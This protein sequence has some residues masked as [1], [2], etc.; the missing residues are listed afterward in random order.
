MSCK[1]LRGDLN[2]AWPTAEIAVMGAKGAVEVISKYKKE[3]AQAED[4]AAKTQEKIDEYETAFGVPYIAAERGYID[5]VILPSE[6]RERLVMALEA[7]SS[8]VEMVPAKKHGN[9][10]Q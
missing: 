9:I 3:I 5:E 10:P 6:T 1:Q 2:Y 7:L 8:K 4:K